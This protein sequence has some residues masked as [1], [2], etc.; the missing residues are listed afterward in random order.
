MQAPS[1][2]KRKHEH[3]P[4]RKSLPKD[5]KTGR[6]TVILLVLLGLIAVGATLFAHW[7]ALSAQAL[8]F[9]DSQYLTE[10]PLVQRPSWASAGRFLREVL[11]PSTVKGYY[12]PLAMIS[13]ML[14]Y[15]IAGRPDNLLPFHRTSLILH[16]ANTVLVIVLLYMLFGN[17]WVAAMVGLLFG[18]HPMTVETIPWIGERKTLLAA[19]F[20]LWCLIVYVRY[21]RRPN[22]KLWATCLV[23]YV[24]ALMSKPISTP[25]PVVLLLL[26]FWPLGR[27]SKRAVVEKLPLL[28]ISVA[29]GVITV[30]SQARSGG[31][32]MP[33]QYPASRIPLILCHNIVFYLYK[34]AWPTH[35][36]SHYPFPQP[37]NLSDPMILAGVIG[38]CILIPTLLISL[39]WTRAFLTGWLIFFVAI[40]PTMGVLGFTIVIASDKYAYLPAVG[41]L[42]I[43]AWLLKRIW[44]GG[45]GAGRVVRQAG[46]VA[47]VVVAASLLVTGTRR[48]LSHWQTTEALCD[49][50]L[51]LAPN[52]YPVYNTRGIAYMNKGDYDQ[53]IRA[54]TKAIELKSDYAFAYS[55]R[56]L[57][58]NDIRDFGRAIRDYAKA[59][60]LKPGYAEAYYNRANA[61]IDMNDFGRAMQDYAKAIELKPDYVEAYYNRGNAYN[62]MRDH[63]RAIRDYSRAIELRPDYAEAYNN[64]GNAYNDLRD[65]G[66]A[67]RDYTKAIELKPDLAEAYS[68]RGNAYNNMGDF[69]QAI[70]DYAKAV[71][72]K[73]NYAEAY[74]NRAIAHF[75]LK[76]YEKAWVDVRMYRR[77]GGTPN[78]EL[79]KK[80]A[81]AT[82]RTE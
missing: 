51:V 31:V 19:F 33:T 1:S 27:L 2:R 8:S 77:L 82:G 42:L 41:L 20:A 28:A 49:Y 46:M 62:N 5:A 17:P 6:S 13:L 64:R 32:E 24:L 66:Q 39:R 53:A 43:L 56:G 44:T 7:P 45:T 12:Q 40:F 16:A 74:H 14:D 57:A 36:S 75:H 61:Y 30:I 54:Y 18:V 22:W 48:Y 59:I 68:N 35:L 71:E 15:A 70:R 11:K 63:D 78:P 80:L 26:D 4:Q 21:T 65:F 72:L 37:M 58:Y 50:M 47:V 29:F 69:G 73:P 38:T 81:E 10:N 34:M 55:N 52:A 23:F 67:I 79:V 3:E 25:L 60:E 76:E 9:D